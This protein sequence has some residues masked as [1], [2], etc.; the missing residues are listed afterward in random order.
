MTQRQRLARAPWRRLTTR[1]VYEN[2]WIRVREDQVELPDGRTT[3]YGVVHCGPCVGVLPFLDRDTVVLVGQY[4]YVAGDFYWEMPTGGIKPG[5]SEEAAVQREL[6]EETGY[7]AERVQKLCAY[8]TS[9]SVVDE[10]ANLYLAEGL[11][12]VERRASGRADY[13]D[14]STIGPVGAG[15]PPAGSSVTAKTF[16]GLPP[17]TGATRCEPRPCA[18]TWK[19]PA[20]CGAA[21]PMVHSS[22]ALP[23]G[24][25]GRFATNRWPPL[26]ACHTTRP[27]ACGL[28]PTPRSATICVAGSRR[29]SAALRYTAS[30]LS[31][32]TMSRWSRWRS[33]AVS[34]AIRPRR[35]S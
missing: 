31:R 9:K 7:H 21:S 3:I 16:T 22:Y 29:S 25:A 8:H 20:G 27:V 17:S 34:R 4:R 11:R 14:A 6:A 13:F 26:T 5:E 24:G 30:W 1:P 19:T 12:P 2:R 10:T 23:G 18:S 35:A 33:A 28:G 15:T 32:A